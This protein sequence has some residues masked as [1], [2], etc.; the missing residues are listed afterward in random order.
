MVSIPGDRRWDNGVAGAISGEILPD[1]LFYFRGPESGQ[2]YDVDA[3]VDKVW[4][5]NSTPADEDSDDGDPPPPSADGTSKT[6]VNKRLVSRTAPEA[7]I[8]NA[9]SRGLFPARK[10]HV[11]VDGGPPESSLPW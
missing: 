5:E 1:Y 2:L 8:V 9:N 10:V 7:A 4:T 11:A 6:A 3:Y